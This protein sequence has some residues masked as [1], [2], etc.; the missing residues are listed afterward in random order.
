MGRLGAGIVQCSPEQAR[1]RS[2][3]YRPGLNSPNGRTSEPLRSGFQG[4]VGEGPVSGA[5]LPVLQA[6]PSGKCC[7]I[8]DPP[9]RSDLTRLGEI[10]HSMNC[11][12]QAAIEGRLSREVAPFHLIYCVL[13]YCVRQR[14]RLSPA[15]RWRPRG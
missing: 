4:T 14:C 3:G 8:A 1:A 5:E 2:K 7:P 12:R 9:H 15:G 10:R 6:P 11:V 13:I